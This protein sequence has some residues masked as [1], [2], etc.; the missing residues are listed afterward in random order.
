MTPRRARLYTWLFFGLAG[1]ASINVMLFQT[2]LPLR[3][4]GGVYGADGAAGGTSTRIYAPSAPSKTSRTAAP[5]AAEQPSDLV[6]AIQR[7]LSGA[8]QYSGVRDGRPSRG[9]TAAIADYETKQGLAVSGEATDALLKRLILGQS[10][11]ASTGH[12]AGEIIPGSAADGL[13]RWVIERL[14]TLG[15]DAGKSQGRPEAKLATAVRAFEA[16]ER[17]APSGRIT[18]QLVRRLERRLP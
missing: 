2:R 6:M 7:E 11:T 17:L 12:P 15:Y 9:L 10:L 8:G 18:E 13:L 1:C 5:T 4:M 14:N 3:G 16:A